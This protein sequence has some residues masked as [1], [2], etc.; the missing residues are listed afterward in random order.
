MNTRYSLTTQTGLLLV[1]IERIV[2]AIDLLN[3]VSKERSGS[4]FPSH[5]YKQIQQFD[6][7]AAVKSFNG[8]FLKH[9]H[10]HTEEYSF[11]PELSRVFCNVHLPVENCGL[12]YYLDYKIGREQIRLCC[13]WYFHVYPSAGA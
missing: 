5:F 13:I 8:H 12:F 3:S 9:T 10:T 1:V 4:P 11:H 2:V 7:I 6:S